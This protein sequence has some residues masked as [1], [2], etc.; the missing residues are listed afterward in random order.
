M[1]VWGRGLVG[2]EGMFVGFGHWAIIRNLEER[3]RECP[4]FIDP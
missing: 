1:L 2:G 3:K 4:F